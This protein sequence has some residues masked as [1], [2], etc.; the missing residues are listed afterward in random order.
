M[1]S[2]ASAGPGAQHTVVFVCGPLQCGSRPL[3]SKFFSRTLSC[4]AVSCDAMVTDRL[5]TAIEFEPPLIDY[6]AHV[7][8]RFRSRFLKDSFCFLFVK[9]VLHLLVNLKGRGSTL[10][11]KKKGDF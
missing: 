2:K 6:S 3:G 8:V 10:L 4:R 1:S 11:I 5:R 9:K 7:L